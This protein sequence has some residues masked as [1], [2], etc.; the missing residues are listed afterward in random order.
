MDHTSPTCNLDQTLLEAARII[1]LPLPNF[2]A[3]V[4]AL[5]AVVIGVPVASA[6]DTTPNY[7]AP[8]QV[9]K[10]V[11]INDCG[12]SDFVNRSSGGSPKI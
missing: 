12:D 11:Y 2:A 1:Y 5:A 3:A 8:T 9:F 10:R 4:A 6:A 7:V